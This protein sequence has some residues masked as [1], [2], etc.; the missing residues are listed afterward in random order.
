MKYYMAVIISVLAAGLP[1]Y[2]HAQTGYVMPQ[3]Q[4]QKILSALRNIKLKSGDTPTPAQLGRD[5]L[6]AGSYV[7]NNNGQVN[8]SAF[9][10]MNFWGSIM[11]AAAINAKRNDR[12]M[13]SKGSDT[14]YRQKFANGEHK[15]ALSAGRTPTFITDFYAEC[16]A[17]RKRFST[18]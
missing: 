3:S 6:G 2:M 10:G 17:I 16:E 18:R 15:A 9:K 1:G 4:A 11:G 5:C 14:V 13:E 7:M 8:Q 12:A